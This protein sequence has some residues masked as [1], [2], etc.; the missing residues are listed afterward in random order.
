MRSHQKFWEIPYIVKLDGGG[1]KSVEK[2]NSAVKQ[3]DSLWIFQSECKDE[4]FTRIFDVV[5]YIIKNRD[6]PTPR[7]GVSSEGGLIL[8]SDVGAPWRL[9]GLNR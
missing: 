7:R 6:T 8:M 5:P 3:H 4:E 2:G 1:G 9:P